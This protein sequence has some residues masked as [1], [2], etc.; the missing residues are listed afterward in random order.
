MVEKLRQ[1]IN[2]IILEKGAITLFVIMRTDE[3]LDKWSII[4][5]STWISEENRQENFGILLDKINQRLDSEE[6]SSIGRIGVFTADNYLVQLFLR[7]QA[8]QK[9]ENEKI[10]GFFVKEAH[11]IVSN[12]EQQQDP[13]QGKINF[14]E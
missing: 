1:L 4:F 10:N 9:I 11:I 14:A 3:L 12:P 2:E 5:S 13:Q 8:G 7:F 6:R